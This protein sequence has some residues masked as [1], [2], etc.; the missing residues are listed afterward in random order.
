MN[1]D[2]LIVRVHHGLDYE[3]EDELERVKHV[4]QSS[5]RL[6]A[7]RVEHDAHLFQY[8]AVGKR[9]R[10]QPHDVVVE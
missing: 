6:S 4:D 10:E 7:R 9:S 1:I 2:V 5:D 8:D 3:F